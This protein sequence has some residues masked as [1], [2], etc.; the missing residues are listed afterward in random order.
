MRYDNAMKILSTLT[1]AALLG[2]SMLV[3]AQIYKWVDDNGNVVYSDVPNS[4]AEEFTPPSMNAVAMPKPRSEPESEKQTP[5]FVAYKSL[6]ILSP[7]PDEVVRN[8]TGAVT[9][10]LKAEPGLQDGHYYSVFVDGHAMIKR[11]ENDSVT[12]TD[13]NRGEHK[14]NAVIRNNTGKVLKRSN[15]VYF[16]MKRESILNR[17]GAANAAGP[18]NNASNTVKPGPQTPAFRPGPLSSQFKPG[19][20]TT[21]PT[22]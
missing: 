7:K 20:L 15:N 17:K 19:P 13:I 16:H 3:S 10:T 2:T 4:K 14:I 9:V 22:P 5:K 1:M 18:R 6:R 11:T 8:N 21:T 12:L